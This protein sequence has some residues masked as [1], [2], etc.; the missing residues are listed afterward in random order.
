MAS[1]AVNP[2]GCPDCGRTFAT[3]VAQQGHAKAKHPSDDELSARR[4]EAC[5]ERIKVV[6][7][8]PVCPVCYMRFACARDR[9]D[10]QKIHIKGEKTKKRKKHFVCRVC[11]S[12]FCT[13]SARGHHEKRAH[14][15][16]FGFAL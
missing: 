15:A 11:P 8:R 14:G 16:V 12:M 9:N 10:H 2:V 6:A 3:R 7:S 1:A 13:S 5:E 4:R